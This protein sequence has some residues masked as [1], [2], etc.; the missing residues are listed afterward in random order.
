VQNVADE[1]GVDVQTVRRWIHAGSLPAVKPGKEY[2]IR[3]ADLEEFLAAREVR[4]KGRAPSPLEPT[5]NDVLTAERRIDYAACASALDGF[6]KHWAQ[7]VAEGRTLDRHQFEDFVE[8]V[9]V[10]VLTLRELRGA[11][12][13]GDVSVMRPSL[14][15]FVAVALAVGDL[16]EDKDA[17]AA[18]LAEVVEELVAA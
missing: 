14:R 10:I 1:L 2:R 3:E 9:Q 8:A 15:Q 7:A 18:E 17:A 16:A 12:D 11:A 6:S 13:A 5:L 4:P